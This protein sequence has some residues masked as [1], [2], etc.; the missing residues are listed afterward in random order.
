MVKEQTSSQSQ[1]SESP[2]PPTL[3]FE[4]LAEQF[5]IWEREAVERLAAAATHQAELQND[6]VAYMAKLSEAWRELALETARHG[7]SLF[8]RARGH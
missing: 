7:A 3:G 2:E 4:A 8:A 1:Q 5:G 6:A